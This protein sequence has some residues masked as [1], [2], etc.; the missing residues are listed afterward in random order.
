MT[1]KPARPIP[2]L[3]QVWS[4]SSSKN[5]RR[6]IAIVKAAED[7]TESHEVT[8]AGER[9]THSTIGKI[10]LLTKLEAG[11]MPTCYRYEPEIKASL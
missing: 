10:A 8:K 6:Y 5:G 2:A 7:H 9:I 11:E 4:A 1:P 3:G